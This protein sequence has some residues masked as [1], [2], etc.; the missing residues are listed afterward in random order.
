[1]ASAI[2]SRGLRVRLRFEKRSS[3]ELLGKR[4][5]I[6]MALDILVRYLHFVSII[7]VMTAVLGQHLLLSTRLSRREIARIQRIDLVYAI[8]V[9]AV[10]ATGFAQWF[11]TGKP[12]DFYSKNPILHI[13]VTLFL[14]VGVVSIYP[15]VVFGKGKK[16]DPDEVIK[17][18]KGVIWS[19]RVEL[20]LLFLMPLLATLIARGIGIPV[21]E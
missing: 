5:P 19:V 16:G 6:L 7:L 4:N 21:V 8:A 18:S 2:S 20:L 13:K 12:A 17:V 15:S 3:S 11:W 14:I 10:L 9:V 1:M